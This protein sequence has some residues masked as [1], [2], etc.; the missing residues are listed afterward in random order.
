MI[1]ESVTILYYTLATI[2]IGIVLYQKYN[3][4]IHSFINKWLYNYETVPNQDID[5][6]SINDS[7]NDNTYILFNENNT[8]NINK[9]N[10]NQNNTE[11]I[12]QINNNQNN[13]NQNNQNNNQEIKVLKTKKNIVIDFE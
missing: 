9:I 10:N 12:Y 6:C 3:T 8:E 1:L 11:N 13:N 5:L 7:N 2:S 4:K